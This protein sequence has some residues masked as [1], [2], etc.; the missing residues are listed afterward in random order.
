MSKYEEVAAKLAEIIA[1]NLEKGVY[2]LPTEAELSRQYKVSRQ[3]IRSALALLH[4]KGIIVSRQGSGSYAT[5]LSEDNARNTIPILVANHQ[6]YIYPHL[7]TDI[8]SSLSEQGYQLQVHDTFNDTTRERALLLSLL[9]SPPRGII[10][11]GC[12]SALPNPNLDL[13]A[14]L[15]EAGCFLL[16]LHNYYAALPNTV[17]IKDDNYY[18]GCLLAEHLV[19]LGHTRIAALFKMDDLQGPERYFGAASCLRDLGILLEDSHVGWF[20]SRHVDALETRQ[21]TRFLTN[22]IQEQLQDC[23]AVICYNDEI[24]YW[25]MKELAYAGRQVPQEISVVCFD[26][27]YLSDL[28]RVRITALTHKP[29]EMGNCAAECMI[30]KLKGIPVASQEIPWQLIRKESDAP[31]QT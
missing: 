1:R 16:F 8:R 11:E 12:K 18:G 9:S 23:T 25:L 31:C 28:S 24:A 10:V 2:K 7:L 21:D 3:T 19:S 6:E 4:A 26:N 17:C 15:R 30:H 14:R 29:H 20:T 13:Y 27:S 22:F 5:G